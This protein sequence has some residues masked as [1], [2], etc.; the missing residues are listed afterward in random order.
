MSIAQ[1]NDE[2]QCYFW[3]AWDGNPCLVAENHA[4]NTKVVLLD[5]DL[6]HPE[7]DLR[8]HDN[9]R[10]IVYRLSPR[11]K[12]GEYCTYGNRMKANFAL[13][14]LNPFDTTPPQQHVATEVAEEN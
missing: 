1:T 13:A 7:S 12:Y 6:T 14:N 2:F 5:R 11:F 9:K 10:W 4:D 8:R 3:T